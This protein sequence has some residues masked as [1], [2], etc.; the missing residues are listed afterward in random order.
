MAV[1]FISPKQRQKMFFMGISG[2][3][4]L[5]MGAVAIGVFFAPEKQVDQSVVFNEPKIS[6]N[7]KIFDSDKFKNLVPFSDMEFQYSY[8]GVDAN[9]KPFSGYISATSPDEAASKLTSQGY[10]NLNIN[11]VQLG[12]D[13]PF[14][15]YYARQIAPATK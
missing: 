10:S 6:V 9:K 14:A 11:Q 12:R 1:V 2:I 13:N 8:T 7:T 3:A 4:L 15:P 5:F